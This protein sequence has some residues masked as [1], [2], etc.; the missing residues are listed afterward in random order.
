MLLK[1]FHMVPQ[2]GA[3]A[4]VDVTKRPI[5]TISVAEESRFPR[6]HHN[7]LK[8]IPPIG[9]EQMRHAFVDKIERTIGNE[10]ERLIAVE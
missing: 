8:Q 4:H 5:G 3:V 10:E 2:V 1:L 6:V 9:I 7:H